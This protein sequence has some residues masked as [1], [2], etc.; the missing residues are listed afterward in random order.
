MTLSVSMTV[1]V[2]ALNFAF[3][4]GQP[5]PSSL[6]VGSQRNAAPIPGRPVEWWVAVREAGAPL[7]RL[8]SRVLLDACS[9]A[10]GPLEV[11]RVW[12]SGHERLWHIGINYSHGIW[13][14]VAEEHHY[15]MAAR[16]ELPPLDRMF[17]SFD[18]PAGLAD[19]VV[20][21]HAA[22]IGELDPGFECPRGA[23][24]SSRGWWI[25]DPTSTATL[26]WKEHDAVIEVSGPYPS[27]VLAD[28]ATGIRWLDGASGR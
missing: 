17:P 4:Q 21:S 3:Q 25:Y 5:N 20:R 9:D 19:G 2:L 18:Y 26:S 13:M 16:T 8:P 24:N 27:G 6:F 12:S 11:R 1:I 23:G 28:L 22:W 7:P 10:A 14:T 15:R